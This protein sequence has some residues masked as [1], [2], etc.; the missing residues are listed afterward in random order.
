MKAV[1]DQKRALLDQKQRDLGRNTVRGGRLAAR[2][3]ASLR[4]AAWLRAGAVDAGSTDVFR[5]CFWFPRCF[6]R[7]PTP[8]WRP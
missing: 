4:C 7:R 1:V 8:R 6:P 3:A 2:C 5:R